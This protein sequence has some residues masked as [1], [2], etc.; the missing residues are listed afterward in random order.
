MKEL[1]LKIPSKIGEYTWFMKKINHYR[2]DLSQESFSFV[3]RPKDNDDNGWL[4]F[5]DKDPEIAL[6]KML[7]WINK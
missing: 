6:T 1:L 5:N 2:G 3:L 7:S 4:Y